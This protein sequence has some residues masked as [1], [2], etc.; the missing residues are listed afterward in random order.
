MLKSSHDKE[1]SICLILDLEINKCEMQIKPKLKK[2]NLNRA[3]KFPQASLEYCEICLKCLYFLCLCVSSCS[4]QSYRFSLG[5]QYLISSKMRFLKKGAG[6]F[7]CSISCTSKQ[8]TRGCAQL[9]PVSMETFQQ[10]RYLLATEQRISYC[11]AE[12]AKCKLH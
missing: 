1:N 2:W 6:F 9:C 7:G 8:G 10:T 11:S 3:F 12:E 4:L 5:N